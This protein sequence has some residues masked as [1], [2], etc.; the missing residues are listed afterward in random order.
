MRRFDFT[1]SSPW[2]GVS[3]TAATMQALMTQCEAI[4]QIKLRHP[5]LIEWRLDYW[6]VGQLNQLETLQRANR[7]LRASFPNQPLLLT[8]RTRAEGG[9]LALKA[10]DYWQQL[11]FIS[12]HLEDD[13]LDVM[14]A[15]LPPN[16]SRTTL[17]QLHSGS[18]VLSHH[19]LQHST[20]TDSVAAMHR[21]LAWARPSDV[22]KLA[23]AVHNDQEMLSLLNA[24]LQVSAHTP[25]SLI[26]MGMGEP[27]Q[28]SRSVGS[29][30]GS[31]LSFGAV[32]I[33]SAPGQISLTK[34]DDLLIDHAEGGFNHETQS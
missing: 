24:T 3:I 18:L 30:F 22:V 4:Q 11:Q 26:T 2:L 21:L 14:P 15:Q 23:V 28:V 7:Y 17:W 27:G 25:I 16:I 20:Y 8:L 33:A 19:N 9:Q 12:A 32:G 31:V 10:E 1:S 6:P 5:L 34:L 29:V 13:L